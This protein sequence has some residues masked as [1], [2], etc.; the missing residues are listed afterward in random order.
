M[1]ADIYIDD[2][3]LGV[4]LIREEGKRPYVDWKTVEALLEFAE[5]I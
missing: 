5:V 3:A 4:P 2:A 1:Y